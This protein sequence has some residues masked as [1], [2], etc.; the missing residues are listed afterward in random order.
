MPIVFDCE[1]SQIARTVA[2]I[3]ENTRAF[4]GKLEPGIFDKVAQLP[5]IEHLYTNFPEGKINRSEL[6]IGGKTV[7]QL[8]AEMKERDINYTDD[9]LKKMPT[10]P[11]P[12]QATLI[13]LKVGD[14]GFTSSPTTDDVYARAAE[15]GLELCPAEVGPHQ[16]L[17]DTEQP[18]GNWYRIAMEQI[19]GR[20]G[21]PSV[22]DLARDGDG[23][24][25]D[26]DWVGPD[27][28]WH[29]G[30]EFVFRLRNVSR[31]PETP[32][33]FVPQFEL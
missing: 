15:L 24:W 18:L 13:R 14:L 32:Q 19:A 21:Y 25:L 6:T 10:L 9:M 29:L 20:H 5:G 30:I 28:R 17:Q 7:D 31:E 4:V 27:G 26:S 11:N 12:E 16:R 33:S 3:N 8:R 1:P 2:E 22:F 23:L